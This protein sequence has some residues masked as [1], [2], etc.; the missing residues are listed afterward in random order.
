MIS[1]L[2][3][4][5][6]R[7]KPEKITVDVNGVGY[8]VSVPMN[9]W[10]E[11]TNGKEAT[12]HI[13]TY[14]REDRLDLFGFLDVN[15]RTLFERFIAM[16]GIGPKHA[17]ELCAVPKSL[18]MQAI[19]SQ[20]P[21]LLTSVK[22]IGKKTAEK[23]LLDLKA[24]AEKQ[25]EIFGVIDHKSPIASQTYDQDVIDALKNLGYDTG[26]IITVL[27]DLPA[28]LKTSEEKVAAAL[29]SM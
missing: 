5:I 20:E 25:P 3:G 18:L 8:G 2:R 10:D 9:V 19:G 6:H 4:T 28:E 21:K 1:H 16:N 17:L 14:V 7:H 12:L 27:K 22:G 15:G 29:R 26:A 13:L 23:L 24:L 11:L